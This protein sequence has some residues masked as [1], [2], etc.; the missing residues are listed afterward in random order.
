M[1]LKVDFLGPLQLGLGVQVVGGFEADVRSDV[2]VLVFLVVVLGL[3]W[4][5]ESL[6]L[7]V[8]AVVRGIRFDRQWH[9]RNVFDVAN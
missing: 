2:A 8:Q 7:R 4:L 9:L 1:L 5:V 6:E 3:R